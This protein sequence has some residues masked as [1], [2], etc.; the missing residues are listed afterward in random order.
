M[1]VQWAQLMKF[2]QSNTIITS[3]E[4]KEFTLIIEIDVKF[5]SIS[6][7]KT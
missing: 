6:L 3:L 2:L 4:I 1:R 7:R 5:I